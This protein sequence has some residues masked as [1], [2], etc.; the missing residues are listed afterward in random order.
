SDGIIRLSGNYQ[1]SITD[2]SSF[3]QTLAVETGDANTYSESVSSLTASLMGDLALR[4]SYTMRSNSDVPLGAEETDTY[5][6]VSV[7]YTF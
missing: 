1:W 3:T 4:L 2:N 5:T 7:L 6:A